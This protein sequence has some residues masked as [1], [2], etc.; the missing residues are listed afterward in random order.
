MGIPAVADAIV[1]INCSWFGLS[2]LLKPRLCRGKS[3][4]STPHDPHLSGFNVQGR[5]SFLARECD[6]TWAMVVDLQ[7]E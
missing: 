1:V 4:S 6:G 2:M 5:A 7:L 3:V